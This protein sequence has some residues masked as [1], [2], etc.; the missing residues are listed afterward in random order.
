MA[1]VNAVAGGEERVCYNCNQPG[2]LRED[3]PSLRT[4]VRVCLYQQAAR[5]RG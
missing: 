2:H 1:G 5:G 3:S 4:E